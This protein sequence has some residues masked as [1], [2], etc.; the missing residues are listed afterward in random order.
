MAPIVGS[1][2]V[3]VILG[4]GELNYRSFGACVHAKCIPV[5]YRCCKIPI[6]CAIPKNQYGHLYT[7]RPSHMPVYRQ[8]Q[9]HKKKKRNNSAT[10]ASLKIQLLADCF[11]FFDVLFHL[12]LSINEHITAVL[13]VVI[14]YF[15]FLVPYYSRCVRVRVLT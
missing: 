1:F 4:E 5:P 2:L 10:Y 12:L 9:I 14:M 7:Q 3:C 15:V 13:F 8:S 6:I 11:D